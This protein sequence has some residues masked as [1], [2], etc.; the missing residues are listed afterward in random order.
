MQPG[1]CE[2]YPPY[3]T[4]DLN[5]VWCTD[6]N[7]KQ[8]FHGRCLDCTNTSCIL[9]ES[10]YFLSENI[11]KSCSLFDIHCAQCSES[12][13][14]CVWPYVPINKSCTFGGY[15]EFSS[16]YYTVL[17]SADSIQLTVNRIGLFNGNVSIS[18]ILIPITAQFIGIPDYGL[19][20]G[21]LSFNSSESFKNIRI[22]VYNSFIDKNY[23]NKL[24]LLLYDPVGAVVYNSNLN[25][26][27]D[28]T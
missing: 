27:L 22:V 15:L 18:F 13:D 1:I 19:T 20:S 25:S 28:Y 6:L 10:G 3:Y 12:C 11:C 4:K 9:C 23:T 8:K 17:K 2:C 24:Y 14:L 26:I 21:I 16:K 5:S 7:C